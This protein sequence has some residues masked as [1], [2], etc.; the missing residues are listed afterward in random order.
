[1]P[2]DF[3]DLLTELEGWLFLHA[4]AIHAQLKSGATDAD[5]GSL[6]RQLGRKLP[7]AFH[8]LY[9][10]HAYWGQAFG[11]DH[12]PLGHVA[13]EWQTWRELEQQWREEH[14][15]LDEEHVSHPAGAIQTEYA[16]PGWI[17]FLKDWGGNSVGIDLNPGPQGVVEQVITF[18]RDEDH[19]YVLADSLEGFVELYVERLRTGQVR[20]EQLSGY[21]EPAWSIQLTDESGFSTDM[22]QTLPDF[23]P[24]FGAAPARRSR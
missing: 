7:D 20:V 23:Y 18:G 13:F 8:M 3:P 22:Y 21:A 14:W 11:L 2:A 5:L 4:P 1:M 10:R 16:T 19:K 12:V 24:G 6:E 9:Q 17:G 15:G